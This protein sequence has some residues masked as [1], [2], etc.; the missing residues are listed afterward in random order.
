[1]HLARISF[2]ILAIL[3]LVQRCR[4][5]CV[6]FGMCNKKQFCRTNKQPEAIAGDDLKRICDMDSPL[7]CCDKKQLDTLEENFLMLSIL[8][9]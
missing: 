6:M 3:L 9:R 4:S 1:M 2:Y 7:Q 5:D 8:V